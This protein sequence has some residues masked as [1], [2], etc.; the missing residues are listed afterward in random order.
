MPLRL[1]NSLFGI[2][3]SVLMANVVLSTTP[4][5]AELRKLKLGNKMP[6]FS[7]VDLN[8]KTFAYKHNRKR[9]LLIAFLSANQQQSKNAASDIKE[10]LAGLPG[11]AEL[12]DFFGVMSE[13]PKKDFLG[14]DEEDSKVAFPILLD[15]QYKLWGKLGIIA[16][17]TVLVIGKDDRALWIRA[18]HAYDFAPA[19]RSNLSYALGIVGEGAPKES[20]EVKALNNATAGARARRHLQ[21][22]KMLEQK[23]RLD[24]AI[25]EVR[26]AQALDPNSVEPA[27]ELGNLFCRSGK[28][29]AALD[30][31]AKIRVTK[32]LDKARLLLISGW[33]K[34]QMG[35][36]DAAEKLLLEATTLDPKSTR[37]LFELGKVYQSKQ[38]IDKAMKSYH[39]ALTIIFNE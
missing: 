10:V 6:E 38:E 27:L 35:D 33:A 9:V 15:S 39:K 36:L 2:F 22:A 26:K 11:K 18:G 1:K 24:S 37:A 21:I 23:G 16:M 8:G 5:Q 17:Q 13:P 3:I 34:R 32:R 25:T 20:V 19:L 7:L 29:K 31:V 12:F 30:I 4:S 14:P 28:S